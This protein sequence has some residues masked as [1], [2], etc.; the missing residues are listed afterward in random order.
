MAD[1]SMTHYTGTYADAIRTPKKYQVGEKWDRYLEILK[2]QDAKKQSFQDAI[3]RV[4]DLG[5]TAYAMKTLPFYFFP[6]TAPFAAGIDLVEGLA[7]GDQGQAAMSLLGAP[8]KVMKGAAA[9]M[10]TMM[11]DEAEGAK[12]PKGL[13]S[14]LLDWK[15]SGRSKFRPSAEPGSEAHK[16]AWRQLD[17]FNSKVKESWDPGDVDAARSMILDGEKASDVT[18]LLDKIAAHDKGKLLGSEFPFKVDVIQGGKTA[19][20]TF[21]EAV[22][23]QQKAKQVAKTGFPKKLSKQEQ[24]ELIKQV[25]GDA[26]TKLFDMAKRES[27][28]KAG[29]EVR[30]GLTKLGLNAEDIIANIS[31][32]PDTAML[33]ISDIKDTLIR[34]NLGKISAS[35]LGARLARAIKT[36]VA[37]T[38]PGSVS[39][40]GARADI[41]R[42]LNITSSGRLTKKSAEYLDAA[43]SAIRGKL[44]TRTKQR[45]RELLKKTGDLVV[46]TS[47]K[48]R[49]IVNIGDKS[50]TFSKQ[51]IDKVDSWV[52]Q[53]LDDR[54]IS[55]IF[56]KPTIEQASEFSSI[57]G[58]KVRPS[59]FN[60]LDAAGF[61]FTKT[62]PKTGSIKNQA[63]QVVGFIER[64]TIRQE[65]RIL[66]RNLK[67]EERETFG[68]LDF[69]LSDL[70][71]Q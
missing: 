4:K 14:R 28:V 6:P 25:M 20:R 2:E 42:E 45:V 61:S 5:S 50:K 36:P 52:N 41:L 21:D 29:N 47:T 12:V 65:K 10:T 66:F 53:A 32:T 69:I 24:D 37:V 64:K 31:K 43:S 3:S 34:F 49:I 39:D 15:S 38:P 9:A 59:A 71:G 7:S 60:R 58:R 51:N 70:I 67:G 62:G 27:I 46:S 48:D 54:G 17:T 33:R 22:G 56:T 44:N 57:I 68:N 35:D 30:E 11:P 40:L 23:I 16:Q 63:G 13:F 1:N 19:P 55:R 8:G 18:M 26:N